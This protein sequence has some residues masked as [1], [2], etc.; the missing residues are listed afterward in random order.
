MEPVSSLGKYGRGLML[1]AGVILLMIGISLIIIQQGTHDNNECLAEIVEINYSDEL[2]HTAENT[3]VTVRYPVGGHTVTA[4]LGQY[5]ASW[6]VGDKIMIQYDPD[7]PSNVRTRTMTYLGWII[8]IA[9]MPFLS[10]G[11][12]MTISIR[13]R[14]AKTPE[15]IA[16]DEERTT[17]GK[18]KY[19]VSSIVIPLCA[20]IPVWAIGIIF[21][22]LEHNSMLGT[23]AAI[24]GCICI[25]AGFRSV[26]YYVI[27]KYRRRHLAAKQPSEV[28]SEDPVFEALTSDED[29]D[30]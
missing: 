10:I 9:S 25:I 5:E 28:I 15:E 3:T 7:N 21:F 13:R 27:I 30:A 16:E 11:L 18:L 20:G 14:A 12:F 1:T 4:E 23:M 29:E 17:A 22:Y 8:L 19:K 26:V 24:L 6:N 2:S